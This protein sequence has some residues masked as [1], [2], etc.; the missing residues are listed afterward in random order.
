[1]RWLETHFNRK[2][3]IDLSQWEKFKVSWI[4]EVTNG[5]QDSFQWEVT[6]LQ[7][8]TYLSGKISEEAELNGKEEIIRG[9]F[10][11]DITGLQYLAYLSG[12]KSEEAELNRK[13]GTT[14]GSF[15]QEISSL[16]V[17]NWT[18]S[19]QI[20]TLQNLCLSQWERRDNQGLIS[21]G[22][23]SRKWILYFNGK[24]QVKLEVGISGFMDILIS[25]TYSARPLSLSMG[26]KGQPGAYFNG[27]Y[28]QGMNLIFQWEIAS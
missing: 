16:G 25:N 4:L 5:N 1:M 20:H 7:Y 26:K 11:W 10:Q 17:L 23:I 22:N 27:K 15:Q 8:L 13:E 24:L 12:K 19:F 9:S 21:K 18:S 28:Q 2:F 3:H 14:W 6:G